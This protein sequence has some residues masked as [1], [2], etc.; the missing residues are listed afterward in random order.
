MSNAA[1]SH[2][3]PATE[4]SV[5][6]QPTD[7]GLIAGR[8]RVIGTLGR[9]SAAEHALATDTQSGRL[10]VVRW[11]ELDKPSSATAL[12]L[13]HEVEVLRSLEEPCLSGAM[14]A[15][16]ER[17]RLFIVRPFVR[18]ISL[19]RRL[20]RGPLDLQDAMTVG[21]CLFS[22]L[23]AA[24]GHGILH[25]DIRPANVIVGRDS[26][27]STAV[28]TEFCIGHLTDPASLT[29]E[30]SLE[31][32]VYRSP[33]HA[34]SLGCDVTE[35]S[36]LYSA[37]IVLFECL[38]GRPPFG[39]DQVGDVLRQHMTSSA[40]ELRALG[41]DIPRCLDELI[42]RLL[43]KDPRK[44]YQSAQAVLAD[45]EWIARSLEKNEDDSGRVVGLHDRRPTLT[46]PAFVGRRR[47]LEL[48]E[49][50][51]RRTVAGESCLAVMEAESGGGKSCL[52][53]EAALLGELAGLW[54]LRGQ[55]SEQVGQQ[56]YHV[57]H[58]V[59]EDI[60]RAARRDPSW[61]QVLRDRL[62]DHADAIGAVLPE[63]VR[64]LGWQTSDKLGPEAFAEYRS[65]QALAVLL[66]ALGSTTRPAM[67][68][69][70]DCQWADEMTARLLAHW[71]RSRTGGGAQ[72]KPTLVV[73][74]F[75][76]E[77]VGAEHP[78]RKIR[79]T[80]HLQLANF[81]TAEVK[82]LLESMAGPLPGEAVDAAFQ[83]S[84]GSPFMAAAVLRGMVESGTLSAD[85]EGWRVEPLALADLQSSSSAAD[86]LSRRIDLL[87]QETVNLMTV[88]AVLGKQFDLDLAAV[89]RAVPHP[90]AAAA[91]DE[92]HKRHF[93]WVR[94]DGRECVFVHDKIRNALLSRLTSRHRRDLHNRIARHLQQEHPDRIFELAY[95]FDAA[96]ENASALR[97][98]V[99]AA[100]QARSQHSL[101]VAEQQYRIAR[102]GEGS[103]DRLTRY[104]IREG[105]GDVLMLR[106]R[107]E[108]SKTMLEA[109]AVVADGD[110]AQA[111]IRGR[112]GELDFKRGD[113]Q[114]ATRAVEDALRLLGWSYPRKMPWGFFALLWAAAIQGL[115]TLFPRLFLGRRKGKPSETEL[116][117]LRLHSR[118]AYVYWFTRGKLQPFL[119][120]FHGMN[121]AEKYCPTPELAQIYSEHS[122]GMTIFGLYRR[123]ITY[124]VKSLEIRRSLEDLWG[125][126][127]S[128][129]FHGCVLYAASRYNEALEK[130]R[131]AVRLLERT[132]DCWEMHIAH[133]QIAAS[134]YRLGDLPGAL[135]ETRR[136]YWSGLELGE[137]QAT[138]ISLDIWALAS[139]GQVPEEILAEELARQRLDAQGKCQVL[140]AQ[141]IQFMSAQQ[142]EAAVSTLEQA[143]KEGSR[144][145][146]P[147]AY[148][149]PALPWLATAMRRLAE[150]HA[151]VTPQRRSQ[152]LARAD[153]I[154]RRAVWV[155][156]RLPNDLPH[157]LRE[158]ALIRA[159]RGRLRSVRRLLERSLTAAE[160]QQARYEYAQTLAVYGQLGQELGWPG[161]DERAHEA[162]RLLHTLKPPGED[163]IRDA[164][165]K[166]ATLS[167]V[168][169]FD[170][171]LAAGHRIASAL[172]AYVVYE[173]MCEAA[174]HLLRPE[175]CLVIEIDSDSESSGLVPVVGDTEG[176]FDARIVRSAL[177]V[178]YTITS[179]EDGVG[180]DSGSPS[181]SGEHSVLCAPVYVR[182]R[183]AACLYA[184]HDHL[185]DLF[186][187]DEERMAN[188]IATIAG[189]A[190]ENAEGFAKLQRWNETLEGRVAERTAAAEARAKEL[191][192]SNDELKRTADE[193]RQIEAQLRDAK[194]AAEA[195]S[196]AKSRFLATMSHEIRTPMN[197]ILGM[198]DLALSTDLTAQQRNYM[199][200]VK[201]SGNALLT[202]LNDVLDFSKI[203][204]ERMELESIDFD[205]RRAVGDVAQL[206]ECS[207][208]KKNLELVCRIG[209]DVPAIVT[210]DPG[211]LRQILVNLLSNAIKFTEEGRIVLDLQIETS[212]DTQTVLH[213]AVEDTGI[214]IPAEKR[215][216]IFKA[217]R[218]SDNSTTRRY[219]G[220]GLGLA[221]SSQ[222]V[223][224][225][226]GRI[227]VESEVG[228]GSVFHFVVPFCLPEPPQMGRPDR[229]EPDRQTEAESCRAEPRRPSPFRVLL[230]EDDPVNQEVAVG[231]LE[232]QGHRVEVASNGREAVDVF[233]REA[234]DVVLMDVEMPEM[235]G[236]AATAAIREVEEGGGTHT[237]IVAMTAHTQQSLRHRCL[238][239]GM[240]DYVSKPIQPQEFFRVLQAVVDRNE[241]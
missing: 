190:L 160:R 15:G 203:E 94:P 109:A 18:G 29:A 202:L 118:L 83:L 225:M 170:T 55:G 192:Y 149:A 211:R 193:L 40:S 122:M 241:V 100:E 108:E 187:P 34:G 161:A 140:L 201:Q 36:D 90:Q 171:V 106:G 53:S 196:C 236:F 39:G 172:S 155:G 169:R 74:A 234:F 177:Q 153:R 240:D 162:Q 101:E 229:A 129:S 37:G 232:L 75:R 235:D 49:E 95:H 78:L 206:M 139:G 142:H 10:V 6:R 237:P 92:A 103:A 65:L 230:A 3:H 134:L 8:Y 173:E 239:A 61:G 180:A 165:A 146:L 186:G 228:R 220:T 136:M 174:T 23:K 199:T 89:I 131:E 28:L 200:I 150:N 16:E 54:V 215:Q 194:Q 113:M 71:C 27:F 66:D 141:G 145:G 217:F 14:E 116:L 105:L 218:Q 21:R 205:L 233:R 51:I 42:Q 60:V 70:D 43:Q 79:P 175:R 56:P 152:L 224:L 188:F 126:G 163:G 52:L 19:R 48:L 191:A 227:W 44:R 32:A 50:E 64:P 189:A 128:L 59:V 2:S 57:L 144:L 47:E 33:E 25:H 214:G 4:P 30:E 135:E 93:L 98:A 35:T 7:E 96:E 216:N 68:L 20:R 167:L 102:R 111:Q 137:Q 77:E 85:R 24:H 45:L 97:Y 157:A 104:R 107:Y 184:A 231:L 114:N 58:G 91:L 9:N 197:G 154:A 26:P 123:G 73:L 31:V 238:S 38:A 213:F 99:A 119:T 17:G 219:G 178:G 130:C 121:L 110:Y 13:E 80:L 69:L 62:S 82:C 86:F 181:D 168:D 1:H 112:L 72:G 87:P 41:L 204:A 88:G 63:L 124:V 198:A 115:H 212:T 159:M 166:P 176:D 81:G 133:Y 12:R 143:V 182:G 5:V 207:A 22:V 46:E 222:L 148:T 147:N 209:S 132:G 183:A 138:G 127:Q 158:L 223:A 11:L 76:S 151:E 210:G 226:G 120:H 208:A 156:R 164:P 125:Q 195:A 67:I 84:Q 185:R 179:G 117:R 221:I